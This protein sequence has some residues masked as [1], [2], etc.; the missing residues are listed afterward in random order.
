M[1]GSRQAL[2]KTQKHFEETCDLMC[3]GT[4]MWTTRICDQ[5]TAWPSER[6]VYF[7]KCFHTLPR[8]SI[9]LIRHMKQDF[10][11]Q[12]VVQETF[13]GSFLHQ[14]THEGNSELQPLSKRPTVSKMHL[15]ATHGYQ[16]PTRR[17]D[18]DHQKPPFTLGCWNASAEWGL[19]DEWYTCV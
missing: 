15:L 5:N 7:C 19:W 8:T 13:S 17:Q 1:K 3:N 16:W 9:D 6:T 11:L 2:C 10:L 4:E 12:Y 18:C 14:I